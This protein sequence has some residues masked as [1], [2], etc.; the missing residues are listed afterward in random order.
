MSKD[1][2]LKEQKTLLLHDWIIT[3]NSE[4]PYAEDALKYRSWR[5][6]KPN[7][8]QADM[9]FKQVESYFLFTKVESYLYTYART[10]TQTKIETESKHYVFNC[11]AINSK[12][13][14]FF[15]KKAAQFDVIRIQI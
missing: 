11:Y 2:V 8:F 5:K 13:I 7:D 3:S 10:D 14:S 4:V 15:L 9:Y 6:N 1:Y 12:H